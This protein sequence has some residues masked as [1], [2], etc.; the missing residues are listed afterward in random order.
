MSDHS[1]E[2]QLGK[3]DRTH[4][5]HTGGEFGLRKNKLTIGNRTLLH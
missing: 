2:S 1:S 5:S 4:P 3:D